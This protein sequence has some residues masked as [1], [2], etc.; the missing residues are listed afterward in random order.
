MFQR[1]IFLEITQGKPGTLLIIPVFSILAQNNYQKFSLWGWT[2]LI[3]FLSMWF[4]IWFCKIFFKTNYM[5]EYTG[6][7]HFLLTFLGH[8]KAFWTL[9]AKKNMHFEWL[10]YL[11]HAVQNHN[12]AKSQ[13]KPHKMP[14]F[15]EK[16]WPPFLARTVPYGPGFPRL[17][18]VKSGF[19]ETL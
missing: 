19:S 18:L 9:K 8:T 5:F 12:F 4:F 1:P 7:F 14:I 15:N 13:K 11:W 6:C 10:H 16:V 17:F 2:T 3:F